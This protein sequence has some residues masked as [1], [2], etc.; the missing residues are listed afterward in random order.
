MATSFPL[1]LCVDLDGTLIRTDVLSEALL[2]YLKKFPRKIFHILWWLSQ[3]RA[4]LKKK[5]ADEIDLDMSLMPINQQIVDLILKY[6]ARGH[7]IYL[8]TAA[9]QKYGKV[10][11]AHFGFFD[12]ILTSN[13]YTN[14]RSSHKARALVERFGEQQYIYAGNSVHDLPVWFH[15]SEI[16]AINTPRKVLQKAALMEKPMFIMQEGLAGWKGL[17]QITHPF[18]WMINFLIFPFL[19][20]FTPMNL[21]DACLIFISLSFLTSSFYILTYLF[22]ITRNRQHL[23]KS[24]ELIAS[25]G[26]P[27][28]SAIRFSL[29][30]I[31]LGLLIGALLININLF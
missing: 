28:G 12:G 17:L 18:N 8:V 9:P 24:K 31:I 7:K 30:L 1:P 19:L 2:V 25:G 15:S 11:A 26:I 29:T 21:K 16:I 27:I 20:L 4:M 22:N 10:A 3:G 6:K 23:S 13:P 5:I 14:L